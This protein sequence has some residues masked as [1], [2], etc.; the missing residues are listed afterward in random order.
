MNVYASAISLLQNNCSFL[1]EKLKLQLQSRNPII[2]GLPLDFCTIT[3]FSTMDLA[4]AIKYVN[5]TGYTGQ[6]WFANNTLTRA[7][8]NFY[9]FNPTTDVISAQQVGV[10]N[11]TGTYINDS[12]ITF[13]NGKVPVSSKNINL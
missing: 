2:Q 7:I 4:F 1:N 11:Y 5:I 6:I 3:N 9:L 12:L 8:K 10:L 13:I